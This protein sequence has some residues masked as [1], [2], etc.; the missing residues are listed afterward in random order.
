MFVLCTASVPPPEPT[1]PRK[2]LTDNIK[3][4][5]R[6]MESKRLDHIKRIQEST[7]KIADEEIKYV[8]SLLPKEFFDEDWEE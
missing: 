2:S 5:K 1:K 6:Q 4:V 7:K 8:K 3:R